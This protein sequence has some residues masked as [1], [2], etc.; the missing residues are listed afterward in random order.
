[1]GLTFGS[2]YK[3][4]VFIFDR[5]KKLIQESRPIITRSDGL[6]EK[7]TSLRALCSSSNSIGVF[8]WVNCVSGGVSETF[9][10]T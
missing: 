5:R 1:M 9:Y 6:A 10:V 2:K 7:E 3:F 8:Q 4:A